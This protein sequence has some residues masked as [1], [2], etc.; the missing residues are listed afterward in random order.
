[1]VF[2]I[3][4]AVLSVLFLELVWPCEYEVIT[5]DSESRIDLITMIYEGYQG[6]FDYLGHSSVKL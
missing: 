2:S 4:I 1:M 5:E 3:S 6:Y